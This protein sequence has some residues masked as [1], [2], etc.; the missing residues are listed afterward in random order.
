[1]KILYY[2]L[3]AV[4]VTWLLRLIPR[5][6]PIIYKGPNS[7]LMLCEQVAVLGYRKVL[8]VTDDFLYNS[9]LLDGIVNTLKENHVE[10]VVYDGVLPDRRYGKQVHISRG[11]LSS[12]LH[13]SQLLHGLRPHR[14]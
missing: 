3:R 14:L 13:G 7:S 6:A 1:M 11:K 2:K 10:F 12:V 5:N 8:I 4:V 9:G